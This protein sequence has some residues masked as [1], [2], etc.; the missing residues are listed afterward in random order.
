ME[1][2]K[3]DILTVEIT[4]TGIEGEGIGKT[5]GFILFVKDA[6]IGDT[7]Q[8]KVMKA[9]KNYAYAKLEKVLVPSPF[10]VQPPCPFHRQCGGCQLQPLSYEKQLEFKQNKIRNNL[11]RIGGFSPEHIDACMEPIIGMEDPW[12]YRNKA[13]FPFGYDKEGNVV[14][15]FYAGRSHNIIANTDCA[16]GVEENK[17]VLE[18]ILAYMKKYGVSAYD[19]TS[20]KGLIRHVLIRKGFASGQLM[21]CVVI[22]GNKLPEEKTLAEELWKI[23]GMTSVSINVNTERTNVILGKKV[24]V[25]KGKEKIEDTIGDVVFRISPLSFYQVNPIQTK[26]LYGQALEYAGLTG[27]ETVWDLYCGIGTISLFLAK[28]AKKVYG[29]EIVPEAIADAKENAARNGITNAEFFVGKA[30]EV[31]PRKYEEEGVYADVIVVDPPRKGCDEKCLETMVRMRPE[32]IVYVSCD[33][34]TLARDLKY[35]GEMGYEVRKW[36]GCD[37]FPGTVHVETVCLLSKLNA[38]QHIEVDIHMDELDLTDAEKKAT[39]SEIKEYVLEHT[40]LKVSSLYIA[41]VKQKCGII[42]R[43]NYNK[44]KSDDAKQPQCPPDKEKAIKEALK[45]FGMI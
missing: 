2:K 5:D 40:G 7:V 28:K 44:P 39:Y 14:T 42:E 3:N 24:R 27:E 30:E 34:A 8:V 45:H 23:P 29:V 16:L 25:L 32:R 35:L 22:N 38:K 17:T 43:E 19:E 15:G 33:S 13:Q 12:H 6:V 21:A 36:R 4:D 10:R 26:K 20:G 31:L 37:M 18:T 41:Q 1:I 9:K 11:I